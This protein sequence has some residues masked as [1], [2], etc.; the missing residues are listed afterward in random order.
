[1]AEV[2][3][4]GENTPNLGGRNY[5]QNSPN[6]FY[7]GSIG[8]PVLDDT[9]EVVNEGPVIKTNNDITYGGVGKPVFDGTIEVQNEGPVL[10]SNADNKGKNVFLYR[11]GQPVLDGSIGVQ[12]EPIQVTP[13]DNR[14]IDV[15]YGS[16]GGKPVFDDEVIFY[17][18]PLN[19]SP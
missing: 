19:F 3:I 8:P 4:D 15:S 12:Y 9:I 13:F 5:V 6:V 16:D 18:P 11:Q 7:P 1:M 14:G 17:K 2:Q 10:T